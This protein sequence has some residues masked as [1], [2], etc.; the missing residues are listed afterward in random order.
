[1]LAVVL[2]LVACGSPDAPA[3][4]PRTVVV[5]TP[6][7]VTA[8]TAAL[9]LAG[10]IHSHTE[11]DLSFR[12][13][14]KMAERP[15]DMGTHVD[16]GAVLALLDPAD[17]RLNL[18]AARA[19]LNAAEA[20]L[21]L[22]RAEEQRYRDLF[23]LQFVGQSELDRRINV[24]RAAEARKEQAAAEF[25]LARNQSVYT[26][27][28][29]DTAGVVTQIYAEPGSNVT[30]GQPIL[31]FAADGGREAWFAVP[32]GQLASFRNAKRLKVAL[33]EAAGKRYDAT[34]RDIDPQADSI[35]RTHRARVT[36]RD[37]DQ[38]VQPGATA[39]VIV[40][41]DAEVHSFR[42]PATALGSTQQGK[43][44]VWRVRTTADGEAV[45]PVEVIVLMQRDDS[46]T[47]NGPLAA[48]DRIVTAGV[49][50]LRSG[51]PVHAVRRSEK[52]AL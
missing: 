11:A 10:S 15:V 9:V 27:L 39:T 35:T 32:E 6:N 2:A 52:A 46:V 28:V 5:E 3:T 18:G 21:T 43:A 36:L 44:S 25:D 4:R 24:T 1:L 42:L 20:D 41:H 8:E 16:A 50:L 31:R 29:A 13:S 23:A 7:A 48:Q 49:H 22:A 33:L 37:V 26:R 19:A 40:L 12:V 34:L 51:M 47:V 17:A 14:G 30:A 38:G 45:E